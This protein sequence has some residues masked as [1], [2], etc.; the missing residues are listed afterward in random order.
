MKVKLIQ[1]CFGP[2]PDNRLKTI[3]RPVG[4]VIEDPRA[5]YLIRAGLAI[6]VDDEAR[7][8]ADDIIG[9][10]EKIAKSKNA[11]AVRDA[12][13]RISQLNANFRKA[14][15]GVEANDDQPS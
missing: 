10:L 8:A 5:H 3:E 13:R 15:Q 11:K 4:T 9:R 6:P 14:N 2:D 1:D 12:E 7:T